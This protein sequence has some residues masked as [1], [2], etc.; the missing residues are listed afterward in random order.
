MSERSVVVCGA[1][2]FIGGALV[3]DLRADRA[4]VRAVDLKPLEEWYQRFDDVEN[5]QLDLRDKSACEQAVAGVE[6]VYNLAADMGGMGFI[7][8]NKAACML[9]VLI[10]THLLG[11]AQAADV[12]HFFFASSACVYAADKQ[13]DHDVVPLKEED[14][15]PAMPEDGYGWEK[16]FSERMCRHFAE[17]YGLVTRVARY[18]NVY[19]PHG[20][21]DG[22]RE[23]AP[24]AICRKVIEAVTT[25]DH[26]IEIWGDGHQTRSFMY[27]DDCVL[28]TRRIMESEIEEPINLGS[29]QLVTINQ[30]VSMVEQIAGVTLERRYDLDAPKGVNGRNSDNA[31]I[32]KHLGWEPSIRLQDGL[33]KT[34][35]WIHD[36]YRARGQ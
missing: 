2:G 36:Q 33:E 3:A 18:H 16:L 10:N 24:A 26:R 22:G 12:S 29:D 19:G 34:Y 9:S 14:A 4:R 27:V 6:E 7:E 20:T 23:K 21:W 31:Q 32:R 8:N 15:Y 5:L 28:G 13:V 17:D 25:G 30:L 1:G 11:A 35:A